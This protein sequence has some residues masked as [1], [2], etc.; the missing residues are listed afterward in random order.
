MAILIVTTKG[1]QEEWRDQ[2]VRLRPDLDI[3]V[4]PDNKNPD[5]VQFALAWNPPVGVVNQFQNLKCI[6]STGA[7]AD[8]ILKDPGLPEHV[9]I[10]RVVDQRL[11]KDMTA[12]LIT[13]VMAYLRDLDGYRTQERKKLWRRHDYKV[14]EKTRIGIMGMGELGKNAASRFVDLGFIVYGWSKSRKQNTNVQMFTGP[15]EFDSFLERVNILI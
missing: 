15:E 7:G 2:L 5:D 1:N 4:Y 9:K 11:K 6:A 10:T 3:R 8:H 13:Y 14:P 12:Y